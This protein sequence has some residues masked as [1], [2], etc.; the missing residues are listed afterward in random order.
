MGVL[1]SPVGASFVSR[2]FPLPNRGGEN[3]HS[4]RLSAS[5]AA[6]VGLKV[7][8]WRYVLVSIIS[9]WSFLIDQLRPPSDRSVRSNELELKIDASQSSS[10]GCDGRS[11]L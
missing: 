1:I 2:F 7:D 10:S 6:A 11:P 5:L 8:D 3:R 4:N 9:L